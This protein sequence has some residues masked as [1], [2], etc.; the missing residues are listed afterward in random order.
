MLAQQGKIT[1]EFEKK[2]LEAIAKA[3]KGMPGLASLTVFTFI[4]RYFTP[5][6]VTPIANIGGSK[7]AEWRKAKREKM[8]TAQA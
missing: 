2:A 7:F 5:V 8:Q 4:Y 6:A 1:P 3:S